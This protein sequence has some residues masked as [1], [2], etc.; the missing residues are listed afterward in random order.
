MANRLGSATSPYLRMHADNPIDWWEWGSDA[1][2]EAA[3]RDVPILLSVGYSACHWCHVM[4]EESFSDP[5]VAALVN[6][7]FVPVKVDREERPDLDAIYM[8]ATQALTGQGGWPMTV[9]LTPD[10]LPLFAG[11]YYPPVPQGG[12][13]SFTQVVEAI[14]EAWQERRDEAVGSAAAIRAHLAAEFVPPPVPERTD[15]WQLLK[16]IGDDFDPVHGGFGT[17]P[18]FP[19]PAVVDALLVKGEPGSLDVAQRSLEAMARGGIHDQ[20]GGGF[21]RYS[22]DAGWVVPH[23][24]KM[25]YDNAL[26]LGVY[27]RGWRRVPD[28]EPVTRALFAKVVHG[29][30]GWLERELRLEGGG[31]AAS[32]DADSLDVRGVQHE[33]IYYVWNPELLVDA[34]GEPDADWAT[35][36]FHVTTTGSFG[37]GLSTLQL[38][39]NLDPERLERVRERLLQVRQRRW[40]PARDDKLVAA[41]NGWMI[42]SLVWAATVFDEPGW[43][44][45]AREAAET[46]WRVHWVVPAG[47]PEGGGRLRRSSLDGVPGQTEGLAEDYGAVALG[48]ARLAG[49]AGE[50]V[51]LKRAQALLAVALDHF[52]APDGGFYDTADDAEALYVRPRDVS[53][54]PTPSGSSALIAALRLVGLLADRPALIERADA[55]AATVAGMAVAAPRFAGSAVLDLVV[56]DEARTGLSPAVAV[57]VTPDGDPLA[58]LARATWRMAPAGTAVVTGHPGTEGFAH[59]FDDRPAGESGLAYVCRGTVCFAPASGFAELRSALWSRA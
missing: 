14:A 32:L 30:V 39:G 20:V 50:A 59:H 44:K 1:L 57:V 22:T 5:A 58:E 31:F 3:R 54:N 9:F 7:D 40:A 10:G 49:A 42:D 25:L 21:H 51:W 15:V 37:D 48:F 41:W 12:M 56:A 36:I 45:L 33:G 16:T 52:G 26:L 34:L 55:A 24:E 19:L 38:R 13:P 23:F 46:L 29:I 11:T 4:A 8:K 47:S 18:K 17:A 27:T 35:R 43:L 2:A 28:H 6:R 53:D